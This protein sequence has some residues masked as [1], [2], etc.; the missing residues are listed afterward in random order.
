MIDEDHLTDLDISEV[1]DDTDQYFNTENQTSEGFDS[2]LSNVQNSEDLNSEE[3]PVVDK[4]TPN[5]KSEIIR[6][7]R[8]PMARIKNIMKMDPDVSIVS[9]DALFLV[10]KAT[11]SIPII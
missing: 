3:Q 4:K 2:E 11:V 10:T 1:V 5:Q 9:A 7:T 8:L 6:S